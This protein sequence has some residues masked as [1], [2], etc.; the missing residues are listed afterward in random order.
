MVVNPVDVVLH[1]SGGC[2]VAERV[3]GGVLSQLNGVVARVVA[4]TRDVNELAA[5]GVRV[6]NLGAVNVLV[7]SVGGIN[8]L[9]F[10]KT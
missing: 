6:A 2:G 7:D 9:K 10:K 4:W 3:S 1:D 5:V 8:D